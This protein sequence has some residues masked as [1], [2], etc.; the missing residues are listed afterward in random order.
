MV[1]RT[2]CQEAWISAGSAENS[3]LLHS[4]CL[5]HKYQVLSMIETAKLHSSAEG[6]LCSV[7][8]GL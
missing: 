4:L 2:N 1:D 8:L 5:E 6:W 3:E 7:S